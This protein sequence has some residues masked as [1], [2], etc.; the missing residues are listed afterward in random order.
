MEPIGLLPRLLFESRCQ[1]NDFAEISISDLPLLPKK[2]LIDNFDRAVT[3]PRLRKKEL[4]DWFE[5]HRN[6]SETFC[7]D[8]IVIHGS[9]TSGDI[10]IFAYDRVAWAIADATVADRLPTPENYPNGKTKIAFYVAADGHFA[11][12]SMANSM[13][14]NVYDTLI[15]SLLNSSE[16]TVMR[17][18]VFQP[19][20]ITGYSS[21]VAQLAEF[22]LKGSLRIRPQRVFVGGDKLTQSME[23]T[24]RE[25]WGAPIYVLYAASE[26][27]YIAIKTPQY[28]QMLVMD[29]LNIVEVLDEKDHAVNDG[30]EGRVILTNL[31]NYTLPMIRYELGDYVMRGTPLPDQ[32][33][34]TLLDIRGR[35]NEALPVVLSGGAHESIHP[36][37]LT[38]FYVPTIEKFQFVS[39]HPELVRI[40]YVAP[41]NIDS[42]VRG[43]FQKMLDAKGA[44]RTR[45]AVRKVPAIENDPKTGKLR[46]VKFEE[47]QSRQLLLRI[48][49]T[50]ASQIAPKRVRVKPIPSFIPFARGDIEQSI[51]ARFEQQVQKYAGALAM[52]NGDQSLSYSELN[53]VANRQAWALI[54]RLGNKPE[55]VALLLR[56]GIPVVSSIL[57]ILKAGKCYVPLDPS[58]PEV[59]LA[60]ILEDSQAALVVTNDAN[61]SLTMTLVRDASKV[62]NIDQ[63]NEGTSTENPSPTISPDSLAYLFYTS[64]S[65]GR[66]KGVV[67]NQR[68][69]LHQI[70]TYTNALQLTADD[71]ITQLHSHA[72]SASRLDIFGALLNGAA[73]FPIAVAEEGFKRLDSWLRDEEITLLHWVPTAFRHFAYALDRSNLFPHLRLLVLGSEPLSSGDVEL[74]KR[75]CSPGCVLVNRFGTTETGNI[76]L[77]FMDKDSAPPSDP[78]PVGYAV[79]DTTVVLLDETGKEHKGEQMGEIAVK[80]EYLSP[81]YWRRP[82]LTEAVFSRDPVE[83]KTRIYRTGDMGRMLPD[84]CLLHL[85]R[86][87]FQVKIRG[88]RI[89]VA[90]IEK[91]LLEHSAIAEAAVE[92]RPDH[93]GSNRLVAYYVCSE[94]PPNTS[95]LR[96]FLS[97]RLPGYMVPSAFVHLDALPHTPTGKLDRMALPDPKEGG[98]GSGATDDFISPRSAMEQSIAEVWQEILGV[99]RVSAHDNFFD[100]GGH[101]LLLMNV[102]SRIEQKIGVRIYPT[103]MI[104]QTL[105]QIA[106][107]CEQRVPPIHE[108]SSFRLFGSWLSAATRLLNR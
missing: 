50:D 29:D 83:P 60:R 42:A 71:H 95:M 99:E 63:L 105:A 25:A 5:G 94:F 44:V 93:L 31:Y 61:L 97:V 73:L 78:V 7:K 102:V 27:K 68:N 12:V 81:G 18:N 56:Q 26:S 75:R 21:S 45:V 74:Y 96:K 39:E 87:D 84:G 98:D 11:T 89:D 33:F 70:M 49:D 34:S 24:I 32:P 20:R 66:P 55:S 40:D 91:V 58:Y 9:G 79:E 8:M 46:L 2:T 92:A 77:Y 69:V 67:Q 82:D 16:Q 13:P 90:E 88:Y 62:L 15:L 107:E 48:V 72:F 22:A 23:R 52:K 28:D 108:P 4:E 100:L 14:K 10:G 103:E 35:V 47:R 53:R 106:S 36:I 59:T 80:S 76:R 65:T 51:P 85:G 43:E 41:R 19:H 54:E 38:T 101:S 64:G 86:K 104:L 57:G 1:G 30:K 37:V 17:L 3:D 6:P